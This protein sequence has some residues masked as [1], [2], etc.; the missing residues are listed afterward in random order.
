MKMGLKPGMSLADARAMHPGLELADA[1]PAADALLLASIGDWCR[2]WTPLVALDPPDGIALDI[3]GVAHLFGGEKSLLKAIEASIAAQGFA[4]RAAIAGTPEAAWAIARHGDDKICA[5]GGEEKSLRA[6]PVEAL[7]PD[8]ETADA[9]RRVGLTRIEDILSRPR[10][11]ITARFGEA[12]LDRLDAALGATRSPIAAAI[13]SAPYVAEKRFFDPIILPDDIERTLLRL[14][15]DLC[16]LLTR[17]D[18]GARRIEALFFRVDGLV[19][20]IVVGASRPLREPEIMARLLRE[21]I[22]Y[23]GDEIDIGYGFDLL[24]LSALETSP[25][26]Q[27]QHDLAADLHA[28]DLTRLVDVLGARLG[29]RR[30]ERL[31][32][33]D[34]HWPE[35]AVVSV[36]AAQAASRRAVAPAWNPTREMSEPP[37]R[38]L[39]LL[40]KPE[41]VETVATVPDGPPIRFR[42]RRVQHDVAMIEGPERIAPEW[43]RGEGLTRDYFRAEDVEGRRFWL[44]REGLYGRELH[45]K[46]ARWFMHGLFA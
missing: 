27:V 24:R 22:S 25:R 39:R 28:E 35:F 30:I 19:R 42:W 15:R 18:E 29:A 23:G 43:W 34:S 37:D 20:R 4:L 33:F 46:P 14:A 32:P 8:E 2:R 26:A 3:S 36:P 6:L 44:F 17:H 10:A 16:A 5:S 41:L 45:D 13:E 1:D 7:R 31:Q 12:L 9:L 38:P 11:P 21:K 40:A